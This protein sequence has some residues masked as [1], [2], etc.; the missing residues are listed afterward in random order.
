[1]DWECRSDWLSVKHTLHHFFK[2][3]CPLRNIYKRSI[4][5][6][7]VGERGRETERWSVLIKVRVLQMVNL[8]SKHHGLIPIFCHMDM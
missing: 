7:H 8:K 5:E 6:W 4:T 3:L 2:C 1:M